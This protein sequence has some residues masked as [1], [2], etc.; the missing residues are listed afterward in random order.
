MFV[1]SLK[2]YGIYLVYVSGHVSVYLS[3]FSSQRDPYKHQSFYVYCS[4]MDFALKCSGLYSK[5]FNFKEG[6]KEGYN[7]DDAVL[8]F[9]PAVSRVFG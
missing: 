6:F 2:I 8:Y 4:W 5:M 9:P 3:F 7:K 1:M